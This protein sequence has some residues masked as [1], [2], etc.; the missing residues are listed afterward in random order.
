MLLLDQFKS[1]LAETLASEADGHPSDVYHGSIEANHSCQTD[2]ALLTG[3]G[4]SFLRDE[5]RVRGVSPGSGNLIEEEKGVQLHLNLGTLSFICHLSVFSN[6]SAIHS[7]SVKFSG[8][9]IS[10]GAR[11]R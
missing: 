5:F 9:E 8:T 3:I 2:K 10:T 4:V 7:V 6:I 1:F 11:L